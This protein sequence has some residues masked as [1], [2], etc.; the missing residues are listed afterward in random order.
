MDREDRRGRRRLP[1]PRGEAPEDRRTRR[2]DGFRRER[3]IGE[4]DGFRRDRERG[5]RDGFRR[6]RRPDA[7][8]RRRR[9]KRRRPDRERRGNLLFFGLQVLMLTAL[10]ACGVIFYNRFGVR[11]I[12]L[13]REA[14]ETVENSDESVFRSSL[15]TLIYDR[16]GGT[17]ST[18][19]GDKDAYYLTS[20]E[21]PD[22][23]KEAFV[24]IED[25]RFYQH[26][27]YDL[28][29]IGRAVLSLM[30]KSAITQG[31]STITQQLARNIFLTHTVRWER[32]IEEIFIAMRLE[33]KYSKD[34]ILE[35]YINNIYY[36]NGYYG[37]QAASRGYFGRDVSEL[38]LSETAFLCAIPN[39]P[40]RYDPR[41]SPE[42]TLERRDRILEEM[43]EDEV[44]GQVEYEEALS[45]EIVLTEPEEEPSGGY[46][47]SYA[48]NCAV[49]ELMKKQG[50]EFQYAFASDEERAQYD[51]EYG[52]VYEECLN[53]LRAGGYRVYTS[54]D[55][56]KQ[57]LLQA[58]VD[59]TLEGFVNRGTNGVLDMQGAAVCIDNA[60]GQVAAIVGGRTE[61]DV[62]ASLNRAYQSP[63]Q[64]GSTIKPL[65]VYTPALEQG[66]TAD[67]TVTDQKLEDGPSNSNG[68]YYGQ[69]KLSYAVEQSLNTVAWQVLE[70]IGVETG[71]E[72]LYAL[73][74]AKIVD[75][76]HQ[77]STALGG[78]T[79]GATAVE[80]ASGYAALANGG[81]FREPTCVVKITDS[82]GNMI[83]DNS[84]ME[85]TQVYEEE[86]AA[87]M[88]EMLEGVMKRGTGKSLAL[89]GVAC[90]GKTGTTND[91]K[92]GWFVGY[93]EDYT[94]AVWVGCD[95]VRRLSGLAGSSYPGEIWQ[96]F[97]QEIHGG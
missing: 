48:V 67:S 4:R 33:D 40:T 7:R 85:E 79:Q 71:I 82:F 23:V 62:D 11:I 52:A 13:Y 9:M 60:T 50:F 35:Y 84:V 69:V 57:E 19:R 31:G 8:V 39:S 1:G 58:S 22:Y 47:E 38:T 91:N 74:F 64:P 61:E 45:Q 27:G 87:Q 53:M 70:D 6:R 25:K 37:I 59:E 92:D 14:K 96:R 36:A 97:M 17:I 2:A 28:L 55:P 65:V 42:N 12:E 83:A 56:E 30:Q 95:N 51:E 44:I 21:I 24:S 49:K 94:T 3:E 43:L 77:L 41:V 5:E 20:E 29:A 18:L 54:L 26:G 81:R 72:K 32:K 89:D 63:R 46:M 75:E 80:M 90:A 10:V 66:Y 73:H 93:T 15:T 86:A 68:R 34:E 88:T 16:D 78:L 76:D